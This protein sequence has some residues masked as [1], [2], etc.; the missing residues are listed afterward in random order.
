[1]TVSFHNTELYLV[2]IDNQPYTPMKPIV[3]GMGL[4]WA[5]QFRKL[6]TNQRWGIVKM[7]IPTLGDKQEAI[8]L[9]LR[10]LFGWLTSISPNKVKPELREN[11]IMYQNE[12]DDVLWE[13]WTKG[14]TKNPRRTKHLPNK[15]YNLELLETELAYRVIKYHN[16][17]NQE[18]VRL[19]GNMPENYPNFD[20]ETICK[21][22]MT[23]FLHNTRIRMILDCDGIPKLDLIPKDSFVVNEKNIVDII[24]NHGGI[25]RELIPDIVQAGL[26]RLV[27]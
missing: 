10:K 21:A 22:Y 11:I 19:G 20:R 5:S 3:E 8:C 1:M 2:D 18:I 26:K 25:S 15:E 24:G 4:D 27:K 6:T 17:L 9:P 7:T 12:C 16:E 23:H 14:Q 13:Y